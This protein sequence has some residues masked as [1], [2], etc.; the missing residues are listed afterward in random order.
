MAQTIFLVHINFHT[1]TAPYSHPE[2]NAIGRHS[3][4]HG[5][6]AG[7]SHF[8]FRRLRNSRTRKMKDGSKLSQV[9]RDGVA[10]AKPIGKIVQNLLQSGTSFSDKLE[11]VPFWLVLK[12]VKSGFHVRKNIFRFRTRPRGD[13]ETHLDENGGAGEVFLD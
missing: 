5:R 3:E 13:N 1:A 2:Q 7:F 12:L 4:R 9:E 6:F 8:Q 10:V 11:T